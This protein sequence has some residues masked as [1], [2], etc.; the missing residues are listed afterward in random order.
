MPIERREITEGQRDLLLKTEEGHFADLKRTEVKPSKL[1]RTVSAF[2]NADGGELFIG[3]GEDKKTGTREWKGFAD[4]ESANGHIQALES[5]FPL[6]N[7][8][9]YTFLSSEAADGLVLKLEVRK[10]Q[11][12]KKASDG[13]PYVRRGAQNLP[14]DS[15]AKYKALE[16]VKG[17]ASFE[18]E[19][20]NAEPDVITNSIPIIEFMLQIVPSA[21]P[22]S[23]LRKQRLLVGDRPTVAGVLLF[24]E[25]PQALLPKRSGVKLYRYKTKDAAGS[26][27]TLAFDPVTIEGD[28][29]TQIHRAVEATTATVEEIQK[30]GDKKMETVSYPSEA[31]HE[32]I[33]NAVLHRDYSI[34]DDVHIRVFD[35]RI[36]IQSPG[37]LPAHVT[38]KNILD[39]RFARNGKLVRLI[40]KFPDPPNKDVGE[41]LNT[42]FAAM[43]KLGLK[44]PVIQELENSVLVVIKHE[45]LA[46]PE[47]LILEYLDTHDTIR[48]KT[49]R[50]ICHISADYVVKA[51][52]G[53]LVDRGLIEQVPDT[54][55][56]T[57]AYRQGPNYA[58]WKDA[59]AEDAD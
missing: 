1:T 51:I 46:S 31:L 16:F 42:A 3:I 4:P 9:E 54:A 34:A 22:A 10:T 39:E 28:A 35:N 49:A 43:T 57:T 2:A 15:P 30:L 33:T 29:Y 11:D 37:R 21:E 38:V 41:G 53:R 19:V 18:D 44:E 48:N 55:R 14:V 40:N 6:G 23:W 25:E 8:L 50:E 45:S 20:V 47:T 59:L 17:L 27:E 7:D 32:I 13:V 58:G 24:S 26:R 12:I 56:A 5:L 36:E 52:F